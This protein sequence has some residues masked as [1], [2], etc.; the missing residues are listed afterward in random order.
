MC[1]GGYKWKGRIELSGERPLIES[2]TSICAQLQLSFGRLTVQPDTTHSLLFRREWMCKLLTLD[3]VLVWP[4]LICLPLFLDSLFQ[5][6]VSGL[7]TDKDCPK[8]YSYDL[9]LVFRSFKALFEKSPIISLS[10]CIIKLYFTFYITFPLDRP[11]ACS[12]HV[13]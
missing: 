10:S 12:L 5:L 4:V 3:R 6:G 2:A 11:L 8:H 13:Y 1:H 9:V 7:H